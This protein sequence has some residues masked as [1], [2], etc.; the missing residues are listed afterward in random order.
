[1]LPYHQVFFII[2]KVLL[3]F[4]NR[5][6]EREFS[7]VRSW[8]PSVVFSG[9]I[10]VANIGKQLAMVRSCFLPTYLNKSFL[11]VY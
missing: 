8:L 6:T 1:M 10:T 5:Y 11:D 2:S 9:G 3:I 7:Y 4:I